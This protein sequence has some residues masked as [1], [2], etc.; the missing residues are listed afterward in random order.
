MK[1]SKLSIAT[2][3]LGFLFF[4]A[5]I[6]TGLIDIIKGSKEE[7]H[8]LSYVGLGIAILMLIIGV[9][10]YKP[11]SSTS[12]KQD[13]SVEE[14]STEQIAE[15]TEVTEVT[16]EQPAEEQPAEESQP[17]TTED[18]IKSIVDA[19]NFKYSD[20]RYVTNPDDSGD[21]SITLHYDEA[22]WNETG[23]IVSCLSDYINICRDAYTLDGITEIEYYVYCDF[24]DT[25]GNVSSQKAFAISMKKE[26][27]DTYNWD[28]L[29]GNSK[30]YSQIESDCEFLDIHAGIRS[31]V[32]FDKVF[33]AG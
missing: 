15:V 23:F 31:Q 26:N 3:V 28:N 7:K 25:K 22:S 12:T 20:Y 29:K 1:H 9:A 30:A 33:Y 8:I 27:F 21:I 17:E 16:E 6:V 19:Q 10:N 2:I 14:N 18:K 32:N 11:G 5:A 24:T 13:A 4:P